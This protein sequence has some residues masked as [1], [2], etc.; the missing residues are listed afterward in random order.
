[1]T[2]NQQ[3]IMKKFEEYKEKVKDSIVSDP[4][5]HAWLEGYEM[6]IQE[7]IQVFNP[8]FTSPGSGVRGVQ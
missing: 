7:T 6:G 2:G 4:L 3:R 1:M 5:L 8:N